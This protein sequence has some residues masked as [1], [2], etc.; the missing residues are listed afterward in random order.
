MK[1]NAL[2]K[3]HDVAEYLGVPL[4]SIYE[5]Y[6]QND[7]AQ[8]VASNSTRPNFRQGEISQDGY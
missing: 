5:Q 8:I 6:L 2:W 7:S 4:S 3:I 1:E